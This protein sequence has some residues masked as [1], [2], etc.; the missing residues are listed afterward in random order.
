MLTAR[1]VI[2]ICTLSKKPPLHLSHVTRM[3][4]M[5]PVSLRSINRVMEQQKIYILC[6]FRDTHLLTNGFPCWWVLLKDWRSVTTR[7]STRDS[8]LCSHQGQ[9]CSSAPKF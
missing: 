9:R 7:P 2:S 3:Y 4:K 1:Q 8:P 6:E 5:K